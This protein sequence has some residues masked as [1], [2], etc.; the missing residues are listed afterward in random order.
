M[1]PA[2]TD[3]P[4]LDEVDADG[5]IRETAE[6]INVGGST[7]LQAL[8]A[9]VVGG[10]ALLGG[11]ALMAAIPSAASAATTSMS[12]KAQL[13]SDIGILNFALTL[14]YLESEFYVQAY[15]KANLPGQIKTGGLKDF[16]YVVRA[17]ELAHAKVLKSVITKLGGKPVA[18]PKFNFGKAVTDKDVFLKTAVKLEDTGVMAY[19]GQAGNIHTK[20]LLAAALMIHPIEARHASWARALAGLNP[21]P[22]SFNPSLTKNQVLGVVKSTGF[23]VG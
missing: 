18:K 11:G 16:C 21:A 6:K 14:E 22:A 7:R 13:A 8:R 3:V 2:I 5:A 20:S 4:R 9:A 17:H 19:Q 10:G 12:T 23:I 1:Q 15:D